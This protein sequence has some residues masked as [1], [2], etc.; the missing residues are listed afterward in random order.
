MNALRL[1]AQRRA[2]TAAVGLLLLAAGTA[3]VAEPFEITFTGT[4]AQSNYAEIH[5]GERFELT[6]VLDNGNTTAQGQTWDMSHLQCAY[7]RMN[8][9]GDVRLAQP[10]TLGSN[11]GVVGTIATDGSG[12]LVDM[13]SM[14][15]SA[16]V[17]TYTTA[18]F[19]STLLS[20]VRWYAHGFNP[21]LMIGTRRFSEAAGNG[22]RMAPADWSAPRPSQ[23]VCDATVVPP[24]PGGGAAAIPALSGGTLGLLAALLAWAGRSRLRSTSAAGRKA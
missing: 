11:V 14:V 23:R 10:I 2:C 22:I 19:S 5:N 7:W 21:V 6:L 13:L 16:P 20:N 17:F 12:A 18:G 4:I 1:A 8:D 24:S 15:Y 9:A 3:A